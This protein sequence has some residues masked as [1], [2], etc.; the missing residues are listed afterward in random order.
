LFGL[1]WVLLGV[2]WVICYYEHAKCLCLLLGAKMGLL[3][4]RTGA[5]TNSLAQT[6]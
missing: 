2:V 4:V 1:F 5:R 3:Q 6:S